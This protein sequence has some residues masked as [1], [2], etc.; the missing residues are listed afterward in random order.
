[1][2]TRMIG[3]Y[4]GAE[5]GPL[6]ICI[7][8]MH[9]NEP[10][11]IQAIEEVFRLLKIEP[12]VNPGFHYRGTMI[13]LR[14]NQAALK[15][16][17]RF[18]ERDLNRMLTSAEVKRIG[19]LNYDQLKAEDKECF[20]LLGTIETERKKYNKPFTLILDMHTTTAD[21]GIF[22]IAAE[23]ELSRILAKGLH[24]PVVLG[25]AEGLT[26]TT[27]EYF[28]QPHSTC[29]CIGFEAGQ[30]DDPEAVHRSVAA[31]VNCMRSI[32][33]VTPG[34]VDHRHDGL[35]ISLSIGLPKVT[36]LVNHYRIQP[37]EQ[38]EMN[39]GYHNFQQVKAGEELARNEQGSIL[40]PVDGMILMP[41]YQ[42]QGDDG[43]FI[44][45]P[46]EW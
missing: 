40:S 16:K 14:G 33:S 45:E 2:I 42:S 44:V 28:N 22:T 23:D 21:G 13:G 30:H 19:Q 7:G 41:K 4:E 5:E 25:I 27:I 38:F 36:K 39:P 12:D 9:G 6:L 24:T 34:D 17:Q 43:F 29:Y 1:M 26:G 10:S 11:G 35:L 15:I 37:G 46:I 8:G 18:I 20:E 31:I 3:R 32:G